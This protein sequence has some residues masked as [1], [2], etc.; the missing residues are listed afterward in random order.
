MNPKLQISLSFWLITGVI[1]FAVSVKAASEPLNRN[2]YFQGTDTAGSSSY[3]KVEKFGPDI[4]APS[5][6]IQFYKEGIIFLT[7]STYENKI[8]FGYLSFGKTETKFAVLKDSI[9]EDSRLFSALTPFSC[10]SDAVTFNAGY[11]TMYYTAGSGSGRIESIYLATRGQAVGAE[12]E[13][14]FG[15]SPL[16]L[17]SDGAIYTHPAL[18]INGKIMIFA[19]NRSGSVGGMD[20]FLTRNTRGVWSTPVSLGEIINSE[21]NELY[22]FLDTENNL[23]FSSDRLPGYGGYDLYLCRFNK[24]TWDKPVNLSYPVNTK[25]DDVAFKMNRSDKN[26]AF[27]T[28]RQNSIQGSMQL[29][30]INI[31]KNGLPD[32][33]VT[34]TEL[35]TRQVVSN[36]FFSVLEPALE[37][38]NR[39]TQTASAGNLTGGKSTNVVYRVQFLSSFNPKTRAQITL[40]GKEF[41]VFEYLFNGAYRLCVGEFSTLS[42]ATELQNL[43]KQNDYPQAVVVAFVDNIRSLDPALFQEQN[44]VVNEK[45]VLTGNTEIDRN[46][47]LSGNKEI[48]GNSG[49]AANPVIAPVMTPVAPTS[50]VAPDAVPVTTPVAIPAPALVS[51]LAPAPVAAPVQ[52]AV[53]AVPTEKKD[54]VIYRI[55]VATNNASKGSYKLNISNKSYDTFEYFYSGAYRTCV[56]EF[57]TL[58]TATELQS[59]CRQSGYPQAFVVAFKNDVRSIDP[60]LFK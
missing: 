10:P 13:W 9:L 59:I 26:Y 53:A 44:I 1:S 34:L 45:N 19:S 18:S 15:D 47:E 43:L 48:D 31:L 58:K 21:S 28:V 50:V 24:N 11:D 25:Y 60:S 49:I 29:F 30:R 35:F 14:S 37:A 54:V 6:G 39:Q 5:S 46:K 38:T 7:S 51:T 56:G 2:F 16:G 57:S 27:Y 40:D 55:Q 52:P 20:L 3:I 17:C 4:L 22:P 8:P 33:S 36:V 32:Q 23:Y 42:P 12:A 41:S